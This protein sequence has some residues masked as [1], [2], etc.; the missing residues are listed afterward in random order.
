M[1]ITSQMVAIRR[2]RL[3]DWIIFIA[4]LWFITGGIAEAAQLD[5]IRTKVAVNLADIEENVTRNQSVLRQFAWGISIFC[6]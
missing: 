1:P 3:A 2:P 6:R 5:F 4:L